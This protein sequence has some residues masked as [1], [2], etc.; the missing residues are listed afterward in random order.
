MGLNSVPIL[1]VMADEEE[2]EVVS[3][4]EKLPDM[5]EKCPVCKKAAK[6]LLLHIIRKESC[7][8]TRRKVLKVA[9]GAS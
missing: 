7:Y 2:D 9:K 8:S 4:E 6:N 5:P 1:T 3:D